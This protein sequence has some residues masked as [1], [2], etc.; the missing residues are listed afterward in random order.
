MIW[1][2]MPSCVDLFDLDRTENEEKIAVLQSEIDA[3]ERGEVN[4]Y[5]PLEYFNKINKWMEKTLQFD[6][7]RR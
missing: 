6:P 2:R 3:L 4:F 7:L 1:N 5:V